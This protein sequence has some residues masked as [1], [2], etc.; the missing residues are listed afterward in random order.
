[1]FVALLVRNIISVRSKFRFLFVRW[2]CFHGWHLNGVGSL[3][4]PTTTITTV[5]QQGSPIGQC[6]RDTWTTPL[7]LVQNMH[8]YGALPLEIQDALSV[9]VSSSQK[10][11][12][13]GA[14]LL[15]I[16]NGPFALFP[17]RRRNGAML[18]EIREGLFSALRAKSSRPS[19]FPA[20]P[21]PP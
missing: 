16:P 10:T 12:L 18:L 4:L 8:Q 17:G 5:R 19:L 3:P 20:S 13:F 9:F 21:G 11:L 1:M 15:E 7:D 2:S 14:M 6:V